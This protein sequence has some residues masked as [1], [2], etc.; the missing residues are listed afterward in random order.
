MTT[1]ALVTDATSPE[2]KIIIYGQGDRRPILGFPNSDALVS[3]IRECNHRYRYTQNKNADIIVLSLD[4]KAYGHFEIDAKEKPTDEDRA[5]YPPVRCVCIIRKSVLY[6]EPV[7]LSSL[8]IHVHQFGLK[9]SS[10]QFDKIN[11][12]AGGLQ[13]FACS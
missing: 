11:R 3:Y 1:E 7:Q 2:T 4:G 5:D 10:E 6:V 8:D 12:Q 13:E 9:I